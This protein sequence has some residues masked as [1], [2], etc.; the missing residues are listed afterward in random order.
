M[1]FGEIA[2]LSKREATRGIFFVLVYIVVF[3][4]GFYFG[5]KYLGG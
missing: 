2:R 5:N 4:T 1:K 3:L